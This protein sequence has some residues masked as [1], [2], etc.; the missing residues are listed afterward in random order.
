MA[1]ASSSSSNDANNRLNINTLIKF[2]YSYDGNKDNL[3]AWLT[4]CDR[5][6]K[7]A[8]NDQKTILF[9][10]V[11][12]KLT[13]K[14][15]STCAN[16]IFDSWD[17]LKHFL[18]TRFGNRKHQTH[19]MVDL[20]LEL[21]NCRQSSNE[22][23][24]QYVSRLKSCFKRLLSCLKQNCND[25]GLLP[26]QIELANQLALHA[27]LMGINPQISQLLRSRDPQDLNDAFNIAL[28]KETFSKL[29]SSKSINNNQINQNKFCKICNRAGH[30]T[31]N[32]RNNYNNN[33]RN[34]L[35]KNIYNL[36]TK[37]SCKYCKKEGHVIENCF[38]LTK[39]ETRE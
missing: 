18:K 22:T 33:N 15:Q 32:C 27:F 25:E 21:Q 34:T 10:F 12:N 9:A 35:N 17:D 19:L 24:A 4:S 37:K 38:K 14:A 8:H 2:I 26:G 13:D 23:V 5:A 28:E 6:F 7:F 16:R 30:T 31:F 11:Q 3:T 20:M 39:K 29:I 36:Q 1:N